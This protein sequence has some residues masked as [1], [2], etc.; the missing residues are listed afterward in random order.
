[1]R[2]RVRGMGRRRG[3][4]HG[5]L[6]GREHLF[7]LLPQNIGRFIRQNALRLRLSVRVRGLRVMVRGEGEGENEG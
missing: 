7:E 3:S 5:H 4:L 6:G 2:V 1:M